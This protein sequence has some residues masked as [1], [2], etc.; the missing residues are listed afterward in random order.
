MDLDEAVGDLFTPRA[1]ADPYPYYAVLTERAPVL[2]TDR[3]AIVSSYAAGSAVLRDPRFR[4]ADAPWMD[5]NGQDWRDSAALRLLDPSMLS[6]NSP[7]HERMRRLVSREFSARRIAD[8]APVIARL[9]DTLCDQMAEL[10]A[11]GDP[12]D[13]MAEF[14]YPLPATVISELLGV[15][16]GDR[17]EFRRWSEDLTLSL[18]PFESWAALAPADAAAEALYE[19]FA[20]LARRYRRRPAGSDDGGLAGALVRV[21]DSD[22]GRLSEEELLANLALLLVAGFETTTNLLGNGLRILLE[23]PEAAAALRADPDL[24]P[25]YVEEMLRFDSPV[26]FTSRGALTDVEVAGVT[27]PAGREL[28]VLLGA[29]NHDPHRFTDPHRFDPTRPD[30]QPM[31]FGGGPHYCLGAALARL[32]AR[33]ALPALLRRFPALSLAGPP[34]RR[35]RFVLRGYQALPLSTGTSASLPA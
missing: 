8:L 4:V 11:D 9:T 2:V 18:E 22:G 3:L 32:E 20:D 30:N 34:V 23:R 17:S 7:D 14:A 5:R 10:G 19:Y 12:V 33:I 35:Y 27:V 29:A 6:R 28:N 1:L 13:F 31:S 24:A 15:P 25:S 21:H 26:Q 16:E